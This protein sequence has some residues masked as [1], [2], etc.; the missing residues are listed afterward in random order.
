MKLKNTSE[1]IISVGT[2]VLM[3]GDEMTVNENMVRTPAISALVKRGT[4]A[5]DDTEEKIKEATDKAAEDAKKQAEKE[6]AEKAAAEEAAKKKAEEEA[7]AKKKA[8]EEA[9]AK[10]AKDAKKGT[11]TK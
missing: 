11:E 3:P 5:I 1:K 6:A 10:A 8:E 7:A 4:F 2:T 9:A